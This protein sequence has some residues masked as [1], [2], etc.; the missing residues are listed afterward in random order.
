MLGGNRLGGEEYFALDVTDPAVDSVSILWDKVLFSGR[1]S[2]TIP[3]VGKV[4][5]YAINRRQWEKTHEQ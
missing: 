5:D 3:F 2:S 1:K 4:T